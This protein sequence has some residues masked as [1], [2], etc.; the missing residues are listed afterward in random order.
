MAI[1]RGELGQVA[2]TFSAN[3]FLFFFRREKPVLLRK[4]YVL[5]QFERR[6]A[7]F[8]TRVEMV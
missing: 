3:P 7:A 4:N 6:N 5:G 8:P 2:N 1:T